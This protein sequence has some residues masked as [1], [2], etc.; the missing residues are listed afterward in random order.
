[1]LEFSVCVLLILMLEVCDEFDDMVYFFIEEGEGIKG[2]RKMKKYVN[3][4]LSMGSEWL[5]PY[6]SR[7]HFFK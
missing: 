3:C 7:Y 6:R 1:M 5:R 2:L 4:I